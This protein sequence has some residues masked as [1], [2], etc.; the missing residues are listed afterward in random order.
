V[1]GELLALLNAGGAHAAPDCAP[2]RAHIVVH[3]RSGRR[4]ARF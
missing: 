1:R 2:D 4:I 3:A